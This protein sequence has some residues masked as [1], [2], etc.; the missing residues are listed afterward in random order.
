MRFKICH[1]ITIIA[2]LA[3]NNL[4]PRFAHSETDLSLLKASSINPRYFSD[5]NNKIVYLAGSHTWANLIDR[6]Y[7]D[8]PMPFDYEKYIKFILSCNH[9][10]FRLW[11]WEDTGNLIE[12]TAHYYHTPLTYDRTGPGLANDGK[13]KFDLYSFN[14][15][16]F[17]RLRQ[18]VITAGKHGIYVSIMLFQ[19]W[20][21]DPKGIAGKLWEYHPFH[22][23]NNIIWY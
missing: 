12:G 3:L 16:S 11:T 9:N 7:S 13:P 23:N 6:G 20:S 5:S 2:F 1:L 17:D 4:F 10:F 22:K 18:R 8:P 21:V 15:A 19:G 14:Q